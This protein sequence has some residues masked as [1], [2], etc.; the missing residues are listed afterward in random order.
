MAQLENSSYVRSRMHVDIPYIKTKIKENQ[1]NLP[2]T[3]L[4]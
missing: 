3:N 2:V 1:K 4:G